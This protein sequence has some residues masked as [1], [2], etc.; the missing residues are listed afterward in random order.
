MNR[1]NEITFNASLLAEMRA[2]D[3][4]RRLLAEKKLD[5]EHYKAILLHRVDGGAALVHFG[6]ASKVRADM[7]FLKRLFT[8][9][10]HAGKTWLKHHYADLGQQSSVESVS[11]AESPDDS[12]P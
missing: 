1:V 9:G 6:S 12:F 11:S 5:P 7:T 3:F 2:I 8:L 4:V 10:R